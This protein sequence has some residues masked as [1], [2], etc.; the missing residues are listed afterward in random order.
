MV[1]K[2]S[3]RVARLHSYRCVGE[4]DESDENEKLQGY[5]S[6]PSQTALKDIA[7]LRKPTFQ[8]RPE[9]VSEEVEAKL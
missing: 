9:C 3:S 7:E 1:G 8:E 4:G 5:S 6:I 2:N